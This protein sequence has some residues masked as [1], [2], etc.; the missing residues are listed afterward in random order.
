M[1][2]SKAS[3]CSSLETTFNRVVIKSLSADKY[4]VCCYNDIILEIIEDEINSGN[5][6]I[7]RYGCTQHDIRL[8]THALVISLHSKLDTVTKK[9]ISQ[10]L[11]HYVV[12]KI[13]E[14]GDDGKNISLKLII[15]MS[16]NYWL[17]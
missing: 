15:M 12:V 3:Y 14:R 13:N 6:D 5:I 8:D 10:F 7:V 2:D 11:Y 9:K 17:I 1:I 16:L 4:R